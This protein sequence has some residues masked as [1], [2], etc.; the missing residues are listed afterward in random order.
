MGKATKYLLFLIFAD[1]LFVITGQITGGF[2]STV[3]NAAIDVANLGSSNFFNEFIGNPND[4]FNSSLG[5][6]ALFGAGGVLIGAFLATKEFRVLL[7]P[8]FFTLGLIAFDFILLASYLIS[9]NAVLGTLIM[10]PLT[11]LYIFTAAEWLIGKD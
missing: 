8:V 7:I 6:G 9:L 10:A 5:I 2:T 3:F 1:L 4:I 11:I